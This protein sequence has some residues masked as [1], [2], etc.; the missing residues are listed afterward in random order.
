MEVGGGV[1]EGCE[2]AEG[3]GSGVEGDGMR[4]RVHEEAVVEVGFGGAEGEGGVRLEGWVGFDGAGG[5]AGGVEGEVR[6]CA[7]GDDGALDCGAVGVEVEV[8]VE[9]LLF[10]TLHLC[11]Q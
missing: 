10:S 6:V 2:G 7:E 1:V 11:V 3:E 4:V 8:A 9:C 5:D